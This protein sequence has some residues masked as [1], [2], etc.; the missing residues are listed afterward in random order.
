MVSWLAALRKTYA[1]VTSRRVETCG[2]RAGVEVR[3]ALVSVVLG[4]TVWY[5]GETRHTMLGNSRQSV[6][7]VASDLTP[8]LF[9]A[10]K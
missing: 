6:A 1:F 3:D 9:W 8:P 2:R 5:L 4:V 7:Q 10:R